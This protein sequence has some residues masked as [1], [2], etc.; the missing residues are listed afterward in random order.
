MNPIIP[1]FTSE[2]L[3]ILNIKEKMSWPTPDE[4]FLS[5]NTIKFIIQINGKTRKIIETNRN[6]TEEELLIKIHEDSKLNNY[7]KGNLIQ[8]KIFIP[9]KLINIIIA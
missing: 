7:L 8:K 1:H 5:E 6:T 2:C 9:N 3:K 4:S